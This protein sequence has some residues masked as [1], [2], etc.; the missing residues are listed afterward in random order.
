[1]IHVQEYQA[2]VTAVKHHVYIY[3]QDS[4]K[5]SAVLLC[6][7]V[8]DVRA[9]HLLLCRRFECTAAVLH[10]RSSALLY[11]YGYSW[12][13]TK[14]TRGVCGLRGVFTSIVFPPVILV[15][16][17][18]YCLLYE[19]VVQKQFDKPG[20]SRTIDRLSLLRR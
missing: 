10:A 4:A 11:P 1:M 7:G 15:Y 19:Y 9:H 16:E 3:T 17:R 12:A 13:T 20:A 14:A 2:S 8:R 18:S 6:L 5:P